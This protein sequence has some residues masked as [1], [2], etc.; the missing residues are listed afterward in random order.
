[1]NSK[2]QIDFDCL[3]QMHVLD[4]DEKDGDMSWGCSKV[5]EYCEEKGAD[6]CTKRKC[7]VEWNDINKSQSWV[8]FFAVSLSNPTPLIS[9]ARNHNLLDEMPFCHLTQYCKSNTAVENARIHKV[10]VSPT[11]IRYKF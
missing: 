11:S 1:M 2:S 3:R 8:E 9:F 6:F 5:L 7:L 10:S 4:M